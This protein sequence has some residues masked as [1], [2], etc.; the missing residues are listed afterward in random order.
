G[1][2][3]YGASVSVDLDGSTSFSGNLAADHGRTFALIGSDGYSELLGVVFSNNTATFGGAVYRYNYLDYTSFTDA[4]FQANSA[5]SS[6]GAVAVTEAYSIRCSSC[7]FLDNVA[8][9]DGG[10]V[11]TL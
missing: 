2:A 6:G 4:T 3:I 9:D 7:S 1:G 8:S 10:A 5:K 11:E